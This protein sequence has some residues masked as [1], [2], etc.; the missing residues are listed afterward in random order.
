MEMKDMNL[1]G[2]IGIIG[3]ILL[4]VGVFLAWL[5]VGGE[6]ASGWD[7]YTDGKD[8]LDYSFTPLL[9]LIAG[10]IAI[11]LMIVPTFM[12]VDKFK[13]INNILGIIALILAIVVLIL[14][15]LFWT[16]SFSDGYITIKLTDVY[17]M[18]IGF[19]MVLI[20]AIITVVGGLMPIL[21]EKVL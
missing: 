10:I 9:S 21:K 6:S 1:L 15:I 12:N 2:I 11:V 4:V 17:D 13:Q 3:A 16:Q 18:G 7:V 5:S 20:G 14:C 19:W 8:V